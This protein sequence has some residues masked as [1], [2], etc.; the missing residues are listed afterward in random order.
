MGKNNVKVIARKGRLSVV[1]A[2]SDGKMYL[3]SYGLESTSVG[4]GNSE[5][6]SVFNSE[7]SEMDFGQRRIYATDT[8]T[9]L[10]TFNSFDAAIDF[11][12]AQNKTTGEAVNPADLVSQRLSARYFTD[13]KIDELADAFESADLARDSLSKLVDVASSLIEKIEN[14]KEVTRAAT[15]KKNNA[16]TEANLKKLNALVE[17][18]NKTTPLKDMVEVGAK[19]L[20]KTEDV[21]GKELVK[22]FMPK[23]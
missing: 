13:E 8:F 16:S 5:A 4:R 2:E 15:N 22:D 11:I 6:N 7:F 10:G 17:A 12:E 19:Y 21:S 14:F 20:P 3:A 23:K 18:V 1:L 9:L